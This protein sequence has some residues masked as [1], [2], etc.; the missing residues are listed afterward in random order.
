MLYR[1]YDDNWVNAVRGACVEWN[2]QAEREKEIGREKREIS[3][4]NLQARLNLARN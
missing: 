3:D 2:L 4:T 1:P